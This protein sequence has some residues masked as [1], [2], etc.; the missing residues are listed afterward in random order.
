[1]SVRMKG[2]YIPIELPREP[3]P[4]EKGALAKVLLSIIQIANT[5][6]HG[7]ITIHIRNRKVDMIDSGVKD[8]QIPEL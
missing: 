2:V 3:T 6:G 4:R 7:E 1:M 8:K 5:S